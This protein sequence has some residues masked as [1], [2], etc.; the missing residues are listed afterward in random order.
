M[1]YSIDQSVF[2]LNRNVRFGII[3][4]KNLKNTK[5]LP[6]ETQRLRNAE[7]NLREQVKVENLRET[8][9]VKKYRD[10]MIASGINP[11]RF[12]PSIEA[13]LKRVLKGSKLPAINS[14]VDLC[15]AISLE[16]LIS[17]GGHDLADIDNDLMV[18]FSRED[19]VFLPFGQT[20][21]EKVDDHE[22][23]FASGNIVQTR[24]WIWRQSEFGKVEIDSKNIFF[25]LVGFETENDGPWRTSMDSII[26]LIK[27][28]FEGEYTEYVL[29][30]NNREIEFEF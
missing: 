6:E 25:Q 28:K 16:N 3:V 23:V 29:D 19:D 8:P 12:P 2:K 1:K 20:E 13:M 10:M 5:T 27:N 4:G 17:L 24:K 30:E 11:N 26:D 14:L 21:Y 15:N 7:E 22:L 9:M 18:R